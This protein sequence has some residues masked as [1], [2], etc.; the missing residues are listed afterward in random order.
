MSNR[1]R[2]QPEFKGQL[3]KFEPRNLPLTIRAPPL[4]K[5]QQRRG[6]R[7]KGL[8]QFL[9]LPRR[10]C[11]PTQLALSGRLNT[12]SLATSM[13]AHT[14]ANPSEHQG[15]RSNFTPFESPSE[16]RLTSDAK[17]TT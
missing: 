3:V 13:M 15:E 17:R 5:D 14:K 1:S 10:A 8:I 6:R 11:S 16:N 4:V 7:G 9:P 12:E 2:K